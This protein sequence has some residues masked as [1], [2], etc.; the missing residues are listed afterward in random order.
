MAIKHSGLAIGGKLC[1]VLKLD[2]TDIFGISLNCQA[3]GVAEVTIRRALY[4]TEIE[5]IREIL[6][7]YKLTPIEENGG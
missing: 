5:G 1:E 7:K 4:A 6:T 2:S 3:D